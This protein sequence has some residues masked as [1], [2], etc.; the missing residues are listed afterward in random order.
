VTEAFVDCNADLASIAAAVRDDVA[1]N[2]QRRANWRDIVVGLL[3]VRS[4]QA[5]LLYRLARWSLLHGVRP[6]AEILSRISQ[7]VYT[8]DI[9][10]HAV[11]GTGVVLRHPMCIVIGRGAQVGPRVR[12]F[13]GVTIGNRLSGSAERPDGM[14]VIGERVTIGAGAK[15]L[16]PVLIGAGSKIGA[17][18]VVTRSHPPKSRITG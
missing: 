9:S 12:I 14:P 2:L 4:V 1:Q 3:W 13:Q 10:P 5:L 17:N 16:G 6:L 18:V 11:L 8:V 15:V 7:L